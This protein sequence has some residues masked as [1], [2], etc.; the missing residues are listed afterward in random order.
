MRLRVLIADDEAVARKRASRLV[1]ALPD[2]EIAGECETGEQVLA[3]LREHEV[4]VVLLDVQM[5]ELSGLDVK[6]LLPEDGPRIVF[7]TAHSEHALRAFDVGA[8]DFVTKPLD[9]ARLKVAIDRV[10]RSLARPEVRVP[11]RLPVETRAGIVLVPTGDVSHVIWDGTLSTVHVGREALLTT[12]SLSD[13]L[14]KLGQGAFE[15]VHRRAVVNLDHVNT[16]LPQPSGGYEAR[17][18]GG[19]SVEVSRQAARRLRRLLGLA[20]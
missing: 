11:T 12:A 7:V 9:P 8:A 14:G 19:G 13:I 18:R 10:R 1:G 16:L 5:P 20:E 4:D 3:F 6:A 15:R 2:V 17:L